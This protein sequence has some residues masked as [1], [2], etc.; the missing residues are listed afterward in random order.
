MKKCG[1][2]AGAVALLALA[3]SGCG[4]STYETA[5]VTLSTTYGTVVC[6]LYIDDTV[7]W[8]EAVSHPGSMTRANADKVCRDEGHRRAKA[9]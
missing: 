2:L 4:K 5:P 6:Q 8:D 1:G 9:G 7:L 3:L